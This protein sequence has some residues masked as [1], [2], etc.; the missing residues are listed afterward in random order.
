MPSVMLLNRVQMAIDAPEKYGVVAVGCEIMQYFSSIQED[1]LP[2]PVS[3]HAL[4][5]SSTT[6]LVSGVDY[7]VTEHRPRVVLY[8]CGGNDLSRG[9][10]VS[11]TVDGFREFTA[12]VHEEMPETQI[13]YISIIRTPLQESQ[14]KGDDIEETNKRVRE[15]CD[16]D[17]KLSF[18]DINSIFVYSDGT[19]RKDMFQFFDQHNL[20]TL[21]YKEFS[22]VLEHHL[23]VV[24]N[25]AGGDTLEHLASRDEE[26]QAGG[27]K[28][29]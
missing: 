14:G 22:R 29:L 12:K 16:R 10:S 26:E 6:D 8:C 25:K 23:K 1:M 27:E 19:Q 7:Q 4:A 24:W 18:L 20:T 9:S 11:Q 28:E 3:N 13:I 21:A 5:G 17:D 2:I 15:M